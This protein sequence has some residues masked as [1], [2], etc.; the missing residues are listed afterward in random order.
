MT[1][2]ASLADFLDRH[3]VVGIDSSPFIYYVEEHPKYVSVA[4]AI[5]DATDQHVISAV[6]STISMLEI[7]VK[8][9]REN[10]ALL[11]HAIYSLATRHP[12][13][14]WI[15]PDLSV[16]GRGAKLRAHYNLRT[17]DAIQIATA[18]E[19]GATGFVTNDRRLSRVTELDVLVLDDVLS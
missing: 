18:L 17:A 11:V 6:T 19:S 2:P 10:N 9:F 1:D 16:A 12:H 7:L 13:L 14:A 4:S 8:P 5:F 15:P 3:S